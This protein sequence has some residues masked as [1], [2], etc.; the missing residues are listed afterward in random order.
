MRD[1]EEYDGPVE[2][3]VRCGAYFPR[4]EMYDTEEGY[5]CAGCFKKIQADNSKKNEK[6]AQTPKKR[7]FWF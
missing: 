1:R 2:D 6:G 7:G 4:E 3:C 5:A